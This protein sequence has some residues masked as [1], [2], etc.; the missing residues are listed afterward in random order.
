MAPKRLNSIIVSVHA[1]HWYDPTTWNLGRCP[2]EDDIVELRHKVEVEK[3]AVVRFKK[4]Q[5]NNGG[6][7]NQLQSNIK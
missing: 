4:L 7:L 1:G 2:T 5:V 3:T 6:F